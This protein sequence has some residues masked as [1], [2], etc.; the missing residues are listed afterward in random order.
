MC[1]EFVTRFVERALSRSRCGRFD[2]VSSLQSSWRYLSQKRMSAG[3][4]RMMNMDVIVFAESAKRIVVPSSCLQEAHC[5]ARG[6]RDSS[7]LSMSAN[8]VVLFLLSQIHTPDFSTIV[9]SL[10]RHPSD[11]IG[12]IF[13]D[14]WGEKCSR[15][16]SSSGRNVNELFDCGNVPPF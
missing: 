5:R 10:T 8:S 12:S 2:A 16:A 9:S 15:W 14:K 11:D 7:C 3:Q 6:A 1:Q 13:R 4:D